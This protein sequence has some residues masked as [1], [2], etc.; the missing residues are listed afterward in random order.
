MDVDPSRSILFTYT[1]YF[2]LDLM[3]ATDPI[4]KLLN[5]W[6]LL[7]ISYSSGKRRYLLEECDA[8]RE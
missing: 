2:Q 3:S 5:K 6:H 8:L 1:D 7:L 4:L